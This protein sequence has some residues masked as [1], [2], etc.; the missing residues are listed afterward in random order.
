M[1]VAAGMVAAVTMG[2]SLTGSAEVPTAASSVVTKGFTATIKPVD[3]RT[4]ARMLGVTWRKGCPVAIKD[5]RIITMPFW[6]FDG[7]VHSRGQL[8]VHKDVAGD[9]AAVF[10]RMYTK[11]FPI[12]R[13]ELIEKYAGSDDRSMAADNTSAFNCRAVTGRPGVFSIHS[14][15]KAIDINPVENPYVKG[16]TVLPP[17]GKPYVKR[18]PRRPGMIVNRD[19]VVKAFAAKG[20]DWGGSWRSLKDY[21]HF[22]IPRGQ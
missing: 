22:E 5:L 9:V 4:R 16:T 13:M 2:S 17:S 10:K 15:G 6:G 20:F 1:W 8:M 18:S 21:Q 3:A 11:R 19:H 7:R 14:Y 12:R